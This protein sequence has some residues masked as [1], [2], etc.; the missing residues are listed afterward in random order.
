MPRNGGAAPKE[1]IYSVRSPG[2]KPG[3]VSYEDEISDTKFGHYQLLQETNVAEAAEHLFRIL[4]CAREFQFDRG[5]GSLL[6]PVDTNVYLCLDEI[7][8]LELKEGDGPFE[9][10]FRR[11]HV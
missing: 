9:F 8:T 3:V 10:N 6:V 7:R 1:P 11:R 4:A 2:I 5:V